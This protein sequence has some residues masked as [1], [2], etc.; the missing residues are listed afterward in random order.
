MIKL[1]II[2]DDNGIRQRFEKYFSFRQGIECVLVADSVESFLAKAKGIKEI[3][4]L[5]SDIGL[6]GISGIKGIPLVQ[7]IFPDCNILMITV[8]VE[9]ERIFNALCAGASGYLLKNTPLPKVME[10]IESINNGDAAMSPSIARKVIDYFQP[11]Q[12]KVSSKKEQLTKREKEI[13]QGIVDG[14][15]YKLSLIHI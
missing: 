15:S 5:L 14:L 4:V 13:V 2:E 1:G 9:N 6:P 7:K 8:Y 11:V 12:K 3:D 10:A